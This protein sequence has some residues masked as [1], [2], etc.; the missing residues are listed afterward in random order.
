MLVYRKA[1]Y[2]CV[3]ALSSL[4]IWGKCFVDYFKFLMYRI[5]L[6]KNRDALT[7]YFPSCA[8]SFFYFCS[9]DFKHYIEKGWNEW[10]PLSCSD[11]NGA[12]LIITQHDVGHMLSGYCL[13]YVQICFIHPKALHEFITRLLNFVK[14][15]LFIYWN[16]FLLCAVFELICKTDNT[17]WCT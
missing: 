5:K 17:F 6:S 14:V 10:D 12:A 2:L 4:P 3:L 15:L 13:Y 9:W 16:F 8:P 11:L 7:S 1:T